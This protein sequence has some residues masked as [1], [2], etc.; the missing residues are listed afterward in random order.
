ME[1]K[2][3]TLHLTS[4]RGQLHALFDCFY[5]DEDPKGYLVKIRSNMNEICDKSP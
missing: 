5:L 1:K 3:L 4:T 2:P